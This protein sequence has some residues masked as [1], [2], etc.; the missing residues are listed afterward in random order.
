MAMLTLVNR[1]SDGATVQ[2]VVG[3]LGIGFHQARDQRYTQYGYPAGPPYDGSKLFSLTST[4]VFD[5]DSFSPAT[6]GIASDF[7]GGSSGGPWVL[8]SSLV[9]LSLTDYSYVYP[10]SLRGVMF[11]PYFGGLAQRLYESVGGAAAGS[12]STP[13][14]R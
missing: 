4:R 10:R 1:G 12:R 8:R 2:S 7:T 11:G 14:R 6:I 3:A 13:P 9:A 5:D